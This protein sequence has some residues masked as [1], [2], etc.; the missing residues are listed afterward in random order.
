MISAFILPLL[1]APVFGFVLKTANRL[2]DHKRYLLLIFSLCS[3]TGQ[4]SFCL[5]QQLPIKPARTISF[6]TNEGSCMDVDISPD[7]KTIVFDILGDI[8]TVPVT[9]GIAKQLTRGTG[10][11]VRPV[12]SPD[13]KRIACMSDFSGY[14][15]LNVVSKTGNHRKVL[16][17]DGDLQHVN[18]FD[19][20]ACKG[21]IWATDGNFI[22]EDKFVYGLAGAKLPNKTTNYPFRYSPDG[23]FLY[24]LDSGKIYRYDLNSKNKAAI[25]PV[26]QAFNAGQLS[27]DAHWWAYVVDSGS[28]RSLH[29]QDLVNNR[30]KVLVSAMNTIDHSHADNLPPY[31]FCFSPDSKNIFIGYK[32]KIHRI[33][34]KTGYNQV[35][36]F[37]AHVKVD[38]GSYNYNTY[39]VTHEPFKV[40]YTRWASPSPDGKQLIFTALNRIYIMNLPN[41]TPRVFVKQP[42]AQ[43]E[44]TWSPDGKWI[45][46]VS[47]CD[48]VGG[49]V[50]RATASG[51]MP[52]KVAKA[53]ALYECPTWSPD[54][55]F[56]AV[57]KGSLMDVD[58]LDGQLQLIPLG[59]EPI[60]KI[61]DSISLIS[62]HLVFSPDLSRIF[63]RVGNSYGATP[64][65]R[66]VSNDLNGHSSREEGDWPTFTLSPDGRFIAYSVDEDMYLLPMSKSSYPTDIYEAIR[67]QPAIRFGEGVDFRWEGGGKVLS[68]SYGNKFYR[69]SPNKIMD[70]AAG[71][72]PGKEQYE[73][74]PINRFK[75]VNV[76][77]D[78]VIDMNVIAVAQYSKGI[79]ALKN[80]R[81]LTMHGNKVIEK[82]TIIIKDGRFAV[83]GPVRSVKIPANAKVIDLKGKTIM[84]GFVDLHLHM[85]EKD[86]QFPRQY[87]PYLANLAYGVTTARDPSSDYESFGNSELLRTGDMIGP[88]LF[89]VGRPIRFLDGVTRMDSYNDAF[90]V[91][92]KRKELGAVCI[93]QYEM[94]IGIPRQWVLLASRR[95][96]LNM[97]NEGAWDPISQMGMVKDGS[98]G[99]EHTPVWYDVNRDVTTLWARSKVYFTPT[100]QVGY[101]KPAIPYFDHK[102]W[103]TEDAKMKRFWSAF[104]LQC[105]LN[106]SDEDGADTDTGFIAASREYARIRNQ[107]GRV[108]LGSHGNDEGIG[109]HNELWALQMGGLTNMQA[110]QA[111]TIM[112]AQALGVQHDLGSIE[113]GKIANLIVLNKNPLDD[114]HNS[115]E[116]KYVMKD[117]LLY[118]GETL[119]ELWPVYKKCPDFKLHL[120]TN[121]NTSTTKETKTKDAQNDDND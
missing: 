10:L 102:Y 112:G 49:F 86:E 88:R 31:D 27:P 69:I 95:M 115:R 89:T 37:R 92:R 46:Y 58:T 100:L 24:G 80:I 15:H 83:V 93:K 36:P 40:K 16:D 29:V 77:P 34:I 5:A 42:F 85:H 59:V 111:A 101:S 32:G 71:V 66:T 6:T 108:T 33:T 51:G 54:G 17:S 52:E 21:P 44:P 99:V 7:G 116:I 60:R 56:L 3:L 19:I 9:G 12:W 67:Q 74:D 1:Y 78:E 11:N 20:S 62:N 119:D 64:N 65:V 43:Y 50:W 113:V 14:F 18:S 107:G 2:N 103:S 81:I 73:S 114:I 109:V 45:A 96:G 41:G 91:I 106:E 68:W 26:L 117:G 35:I 30:Q 4:G 57:I 28:R 84:P 70:A 53:S 98:T 23:R 104:Q 61:A 121:V 48:T 55:K 76:Q 47:W 118:D 25:S 22:L 38:C 120:E 75:T 39:R 63:Y 8:Y 110:L 82:G 79:V 105:F 94:N 13:G 90:A 97:T 87:W 72:T